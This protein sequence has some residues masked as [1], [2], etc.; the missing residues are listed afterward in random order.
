MGRIRERYWRAQSYLST[1]RNLIRPCNRAFAR[2]VAGDYLRYI[3]NRVQ[4][5]QGETRKR[6]QA[7]VSWIL[8]AQDAT[9]DDGVSLGYFPCDAN[10]SNGWRPSYPETTGYIIPS[11]LQ[12]SECFKD[13]DVRERALRMAMWEIKVQMPSGAVQGG[14][15]CPPEQQ[16]PA[17]F[18]TG[19][20]LH[21]FIAAYRATAA[22]EFLEAGRRAADFLVADLGDDGHFQTHGQFVSEHR[23]KTYNC[24]C[25]WPLFHI[26]EDLGDA[27]YQE[28]AVK[29]V[30][31]VLGQ[32]QANGWFSNNCFTNSDSPIT[33]TIGYT[34][35]GILEVGG[36]AGREDFIESAK[37]G[38]DPLLQRI[39]PR[40]FLRGSFYAD[41]SP[42]LHSSCLTGN[43][44]LAVV[45][46]RLHELTGDSKYAIAANRLLNNLK[47]LQVLDS[48]NPEINGAIPGSFPLMGSYM[49]AGYPDWATKY[50]LDALLFQDPLQ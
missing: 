14:P 22:P 49:T 29:V 6:A 28:T 8:R 33:H 4:P 47:A 39:S 38:V 5:I 13:S 3:S 24:L 50:F 11:L 19:M 2:H 46:Y 7:A 10:P 37:R 21:G 42:G 12:Y 35:Q 18:N 30:E 43:A 45:C 41:W 16:A 31:A 17:V 40:G 27:R 9:P 48:D 20:V 26:G 25:A 34:L 15:I 44:Q 36:V 32:Q 23:Y 1:I